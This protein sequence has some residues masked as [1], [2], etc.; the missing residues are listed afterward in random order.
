MLTFILG[1]VFVSVVAWVLFVFPPERIERPSLRPLLGD[2]NFQAKQKKNFS[3]IRQISVINK[4]LCIGP[5]GRRISRD[6]AMARVD[7]T[8]EE[9]FFIKELCIAGIMFLTFSS[10]KPE[11]LF[12]WVTMSFTVG[13]LL[14]EFWLKK[15]VKKMKNAIIRDLPDTIDLLG[16]CVNAGLD[17]MLALKWVIEKSK[18]SV[19][20]EELSLVM[21]EINVGKQRRV[22]LSDL[23]K[24]YEIPDLSTFSRTLIQADRMGTSVAEALT[25]LS[26]DMRLSRFRRAEQVALKAPLKMLVPLLFFIFPVVGVLVAAPVFLDFMNNNPM[27]SIGGGAGTPQMMPGADSP[28]QSE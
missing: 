17:F 14:P 1:L 5:L 24:K 10:V 18:K 21:Q 9:F 12:F 22:A 23:A 6:L 7:M 27:S 15:K 19:L 11:M 13:Y 2:E 28:V 26:E 8:A 3:L 4:P 20:I 16:L 25:I